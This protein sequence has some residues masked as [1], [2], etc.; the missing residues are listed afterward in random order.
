MKAV[1]AAAGET[2][3]LIT[4]AAAVNLCDGS[5]AAAC[6]AAN[7]TSVTVTYEA[8]GPTGTFVNPFEGGVIY[9]YL[10][11]DADAVINNG[12]A[13]YTLLTTISGSSLTMTDDNVNR[14]YKG[15]YSLTKADL[16]GVVTGTTLNVA[17]IAVT[18]AGD[19]LHTAYNV[20]VTTIAGK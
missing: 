17:A 6:A 16:T 9:L 19:A 18:S 3:G 15:T 7:K 13:A 4:P 12:A 8:K 20:N 10:V 11:T 1:G 2:Y 14:F 5:G